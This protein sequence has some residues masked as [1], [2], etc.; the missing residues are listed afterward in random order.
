MRSKYGNKKSRVDWISLGDSNTKFFFAYMK[1]RQ[2]QNAIKVLI[3]ADGTRCHTQEMIKAE[4]VHFYIQ[5]MGSAAYE[6]PMIDKDI[7]KRGAVLDHL[8]NVLQCLIRRL[9]RPYFL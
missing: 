9:K 6:L 1:E 4:V 8:T 2:S 7:V 3:R 5:L